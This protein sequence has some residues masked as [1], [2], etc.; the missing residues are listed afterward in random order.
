MA[1]CGRNSFKPVNLSTCPN[2][3]N[4]S[5]TEP[6]ISFFLIGFLFW[7]LLPTLCRCSGY[8]CS[9]SHS[10]TNTL[11]RTPLDE[12]STRRRNLYV[13]TPI[14]YTRQIFK[15][16]GGFKPAFPASKWPQTRTLA[17]A[18]T[19]PITNSF[20]PYLQSSTKCMERKQFC[21]I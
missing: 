9:S 2:T 14:T 18:V 11:G 1:I 16:P 3:A 8:C 13:T 4:F 20:L 12:W 19:E 6:V 10:M 5:L 21:E 7:L 15:L 17:H